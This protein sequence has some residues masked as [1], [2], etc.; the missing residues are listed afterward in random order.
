ML[1][2]DDLQPSARAQVRAGLPS[3][4]LDDARD[5]MHRLTAGDLL[6]ACEP[7]TT[8]AA[9]TSTTPAPTPP[10]PM[11]A[12]DGAP[13]PPPAPTPTEPVPTPTPSPTLTPGQTCR[14]G[15]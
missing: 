11:P 13:T 2:V 6:P 8:T 5:Q 1:T 10:A 4:S 9:P 15:S 12:P 3:G 7:A 14:T